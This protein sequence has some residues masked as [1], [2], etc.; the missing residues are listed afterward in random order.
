MS[1]SLFLFNYQKR[2]VRVFPRD[3]DDFD[4]ELSKSQEN[5]CFFSFNYQQRN[6]QVFPWDDDGCYSTL[7]STQQTIYIRTDSLC[8]F[9]HAK[10]N[11]IT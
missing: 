9:C 1:N 8:C 4:F 3:D 6:I 11:D 7:M 10:G 5:I 2:N